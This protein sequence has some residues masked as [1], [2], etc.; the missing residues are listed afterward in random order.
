M[1]FNYPSIGAPSLSVITNDP[2]L[3]DTYEVDTNA[4][5]R[6]TRGLDVKGC[7]DANWPVVIAHQYTIYLL[8]CG[9]VIADYK[10]FIEQTAGLEIK[11]IDYDSNEL[12]GFIVSDSLEYISMQ[13]DIGL[14]VSFKFMETP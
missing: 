4:V 6:Q 11:I 13:R 1:I 5:V 9:T 14:E 7:K 12:V 10:N 2:I 8:D 3:G